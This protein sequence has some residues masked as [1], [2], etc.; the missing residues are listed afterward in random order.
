MSDPRIEGLARV[1]VGYSLE[2]EEGQSLFIS[3]GTA[4]EPLVQALYERALRVGAN[5]ILDLALEGTQA[6][7]YELAADA[8]IDWIAP[9]QRWAFEE[10][11]ARI[12]ILSDANLRELSNVPPEKQTRRQRAVHPLMERMMARSAA[13]EL[14]W[15]VTLYPTNAYASEAGMSLREYED[16]YYRACLCDQ[17]DPVAAWKRAAAE[18]HRLV[19]W[20]EGREEVRIAGPGTDLVLSVAGRRFV[21]ADGKY[22]MPDG[23]L[24]TGPVEDS[25]EGEI[26]FHLPA[27]Y[28]GREVSGVRFRFAGGKVVDASADRGEDFLI[29]MLDTDE[30][31]RRLGE[32]GIGTNFGIVA[33]T[34]EILLDEKI[35]GT[36]HLAVGE[37]YPE[38]GGTNSSAIHWDMICDLRA[39]GSITVDGEPLQ[40]DGKFVV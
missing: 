5:P 29:E 37:S 27:T 10:A 31:A 1:L 28:A 35:G 21:A 39:G 26:T 20:I 11:D 9:T 6:A 30:G 36:V 34:G 38:T 4:A 17:P 22:N 2:L 12:R 18:T 15:N 23:E 8:Q 19:D 14:R 3:S 24:F 32:L 7:F 13:G 25:A 33:G 16:F 40:K